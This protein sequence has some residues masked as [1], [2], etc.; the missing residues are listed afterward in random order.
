MGRRLLRTVQG[1]RKLRLR[2]PTL[3]QGLVRSMGTSSVR[4]PISWLTLGVMLRVSRFVIR[5]VDR[6]SSILDVCER[7]PFSPKRI[8]V[9]S[10]RESG[11]ERVRDIVGLFTT[12]LIRPSF[13]FA[14]KEEIEQLTVGVIIE[15]D[16]DGGDLYA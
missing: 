15:A 10:V 11:G 6:F 8:R 1:F 9:R 7:V 12:E 2:R 4:I 13:V 5:G 16:V 14:E 3:T